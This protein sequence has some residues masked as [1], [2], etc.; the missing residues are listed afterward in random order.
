MNKY[1]IVLF[2]LLLAGCEKSALF[3]AGPGSAKEF[4]FDGDIST[5][6]VKQIFE[7][8]LVKDTVNKV[9]AIGGDNLL[10][11]LDFRLKDQTLYLDHSIK[12]NWSRPYEKIKLELH[13]RSFDL[14]NIRESIKL[15]T[16]GQF[17]SENFSFIDWSKFSEV[18]VDVDVQTCN[19]IMTSDN[20]GSFKVKGKAINAE[21][22]GWGSCFVHADSLVAENCHVLHRGIGDVYVNATNQLSIALESSG[23]VYYAGTPKTITLER[24]HSSG[25]LIKK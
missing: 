16:R 2:V 8:T 7:I 20:F 1:Y 14:M 21:V 10:K 19:I 22:W 17:K 6:E 24:Q 13:V 23:N 3:D 9:I 5:I 11:Q 12:Y 25:R 15:S 4:V 18:D